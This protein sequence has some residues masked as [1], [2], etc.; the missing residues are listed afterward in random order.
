ME[1]LL[2]ELI[3]AKTYDYVQVPIW[4]DRASYEMAFTDVACNLLDM[5]APAQPNCVTLR[6]LKNCALAHRFINTLVNMTK[7]YEQ[8][9]SEGDRDSQD[10]SGISDWD[11]F[12][13]I[14]Y[15]N[16]SENDSE[17]EDDDESDSDD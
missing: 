16:Q 12:C 6:D 13:I 5:V 11:R 4:R 15:K 2:T 7:Y 14:E 3:L 8:E 17:F 9:S 1:L 10:D